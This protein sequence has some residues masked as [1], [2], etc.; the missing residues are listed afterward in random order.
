MLLFLHLKAS[1]VLFLHLKVSHL[2]TTVNFNKTHISIYDLLNHV[3][4]WYIVHLVSLVHK[5]M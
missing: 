5:S 2:L 4:M 1:H 3:I